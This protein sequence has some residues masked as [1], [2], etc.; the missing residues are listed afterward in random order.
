MGGV[1][2]DYSGVY[3]AVGGASTQDGASLHV[4]AVKEWTEVTVRETRTLSACWLAR[5]Y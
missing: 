5:P 3:L 1:A 2:F 4:R